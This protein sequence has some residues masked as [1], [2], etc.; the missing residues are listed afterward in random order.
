MNKV[1]LIGDCHTT[2]VF[3]HWNP[4]D[5]PS[6]FYAWGKG[7]LTAWSFDPYKLEKDN[8]ISGGIEKNNIYIKQAG[9]KF[10]SVFKRF[11]DPDIILVWLGYVD[12]RSKLPLYKNSKEVVYKYLDLVSSYYPNSIIQIIEPLPQFKEILLK[13]DNLSPKYSYE[14]RL[15]QNNEFVKYLN[16]YIQDH[17]MLNPITQQEIKDTIGIQE[18]REEHAANWAP[19]PQDS[20]KNEYWKMIY[21]LFISRANEVYE[22]C[23]G[24]KLY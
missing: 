16:E 24:N 13:S 2:R 4:V 10:K 5:C 14:E 22:K 18:L 11:K 21:D 6:H 1:Y 9:E 17:N 8:E 19:H 3:E 7:G 15:E 12:I 23:H 20:L